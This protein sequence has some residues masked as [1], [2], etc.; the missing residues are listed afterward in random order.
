M[1]ISKEWYN[2]HIE[3]DKKFSRRL[4]FEFEIGLSKAIL[5]V[6]PTHIEALQMLGHALTHARRHR[7]ALEV[8][9][10]LV[11]LL[12]REPI[13]FY[14]LAC[15]YSNLRRPGEALRALRRALQL[16]Y[17]DF[18]SM[19]KDPDLKNLRKD[20]RFWMMIAPYCKHPTK[21]R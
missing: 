9:K 2:K 6:D 4:F 11:K 7:E 18:E 13:A 19:L 14:N 20:P 15:S 12:P 5:K 21:E 3:V 16:G 1:A 8:D 17:R 10:K